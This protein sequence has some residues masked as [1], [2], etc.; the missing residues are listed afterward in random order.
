MTRE[1]GGGPGAG[2]EGWIR[3]VSLTDIS[4]V[5]IQQ[6]AERGG[7]GRGG[8]APVGAKKR[9]GG[10]PARASATMHPSGSS[11]RYGSLALT[12]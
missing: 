3:K 4:Q 9:Q 12:R 8:G 1:G 10:Q 7:E 11:P 2:R 6:G 5:V